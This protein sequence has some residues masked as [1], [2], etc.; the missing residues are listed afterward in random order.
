MFF[1]IKFQVGELFS[2]EAKAIASSL[3]GSGSWLIAFIVTK[4]FSNFVD[5]I[6]KG[7]TFFLFAAFAAIC[8][9]FVYF[10]IPETKGRSFEQIQRALTNRTDNLDDDDENTTVTSVS[11]NTI[12]I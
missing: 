12:A 8:S 11:Q 10:G 6:G 2:T 5:L 7:P 1:F 9:T 4:F 3:A